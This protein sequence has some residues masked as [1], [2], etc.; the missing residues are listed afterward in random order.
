M[1]SFVVGFCLGSLWSTFLWLV[2]FRT[3]DDAR[4]KRLRNAL[5]D[6]SR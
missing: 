3:V 1:I 6:R 4:I 5:K 2:W